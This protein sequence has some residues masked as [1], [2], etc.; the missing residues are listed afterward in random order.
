VTETASHAPGQV[1]RVHHAMAARGIDALVITSPLNLFYMS[2]FV[3]IAHKAD[4]PR[5]YAMV[6]SRHAPDHP[7]LIVADYYYAP[8]V[9][10]AGWIQDIRPFRAVMMPMDLPAGPEDIEHFIP[11]WLK[12]DRWDKQARQHFSY[13][14]GEALTKALSDLALDGKVIAFDDLGFGFRSGLDTNRLRDA[15]DVMMYARAVKTPAELTKLA[16][17]TALNERAIRQTMADWTPDMTWTEMDRA[18]ARHAQALGGFVRD[19]GGM[20]WGHPRGPDAALVLS[21]ALDNSV[22][23]EGTHV[24]FDCH[25]TLDMYCWDGGKTWVAGGEPEGL[26]KTLERATGDVAETMLQAM[27][28][29]A[30]ISDLQALG[31]AAYRKAGVPDADAA[32]IF[33]HGLGL[34]HMDIE[35]TRADGS[36]NGDW[37]L[38]EGMVVPLHLLYPGGQFERLWLEEVAVIESDGARPLFGWGFK[39][40]TGT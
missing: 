15:Y 17:A 12:D 7:I 27:K 28:P 35:Q 31:R 5:P 37:V 26:A 19:P 13:S 14:Q 24:M 9:S 11:D 38:E 23:G 29:G 20:V 16:A 40:L 33:F 4:E 21:D 6:W 2:G 10:R 30:R 32:V 22:V 3:G 18:Y 1:G 34:S 36:A 39:A 25:G 8:A